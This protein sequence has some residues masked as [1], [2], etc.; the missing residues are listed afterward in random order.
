[1]TKRPR[2]T[3]EE[4]VQNLSD[5][6]DLD[7]PLMEGSDDEFSDLE[8]DDSDDEWM[9]ADGHLASPPCGSPAPHSLSPAP[10]PAS[11]SVAHSSSDVDS[12]RPPAPATS[13]G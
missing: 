1:M 7:E 11:T 10:P 6:L 8:F 13:N 9:D 4:V 3:A 12:S 5:D 2:W